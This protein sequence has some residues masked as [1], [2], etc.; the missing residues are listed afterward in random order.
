MINDAA[1]GADDTHSVFLE[2]AE[3]REFQGLVRESM[4]IHLDEDTAAR[5][6]N[7]LLYLVR[8]LLGRG[9]E[10]GGTEQF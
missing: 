8:I 3:I 6:A 10:D 9:A 2:P 5:R 1:S 4:G 7:Q